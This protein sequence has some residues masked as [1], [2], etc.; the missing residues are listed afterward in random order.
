MLLVHY[1]ICRHIYIYIYIYL[2]SVIK[3]FDLYFYEMST[4]I[5]GHSVNKTL[6]SPLCIVLGRHVC[7]VAQ[8]V[9]Y[10]Y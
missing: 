8:Y 3:H 1:S 9:L 2:F 6:G 10:L 4:L 5:V 7:F